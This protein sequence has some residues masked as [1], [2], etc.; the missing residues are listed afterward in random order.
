MVVAD[1]ACLG[2]YLAVCFHGIMSIGEAAACNG[3]AA[4]YGIQMNCK[5]ILPLLALLP[6]MTLSANDLEEPPHWVMESRQAASALGK[7]LMTT[8]QESNN[9]GGPVAAVGFC[10]L[11][12]PAIADT[13][14]NEYVA[15]V[16]RT[17][18]RVR[19]Q[20]NQADPWEQ[21]MLEQM[22]QQLEAGESASQVEVFAIHNQNGVRTGRWM[23]AIPMQ[24]MCL[25]CHG[26]SVAQE[27][28]SEIDDR[29][30][31]D[32]ARGFQPGELRGAFTV[33]V[34]LD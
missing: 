31:E 12:A 27:V 17:A 30:P 33:R 34:R 21:R 11:Q 2:Q 32:Q 4:W 15:R 5:N 29:Y 23:R 14:S 26:G 10:H 20:N 28:A 16:G 6:M 1:S 9:Q 22:Q 19:N 8:L 25:I 3:S 18:L 24:P 7:N 13:V